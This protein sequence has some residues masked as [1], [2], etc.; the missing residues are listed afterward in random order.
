[1]KQATK[2][3]TICDDADTPSSPFKQRGEKRGGSIFNQYHVQMPYRRNN[4]RAD[5]NILSDDEIENPLEV[6]NK[7]EKPS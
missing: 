5:E 1:M 6:S 4:G 7:Q 2:Q 3:V